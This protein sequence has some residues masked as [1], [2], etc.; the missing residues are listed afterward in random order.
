MRPARAVAR[1]GRGLALLAAVAVLVPPPS[2]QPTSISLTTVETAKAVDFADGVLWVLVLGS[3]A[4]PGRDVTTGLTDAIQLVGIDTEARRAV[5]LGIPRDTWVDLEG[6]AARLN[7][8]LSQEGP[9]AVAR[10]VEDLVGITP[11]LVLVTGFEGFLAMIGSLGEIEVDSTQAFRTEDAGMAVSRGPNRFDARQALEFSRS[12]RTLPRGDFDRS[13]NHQQV[14]IGALTQLRAREDDEGFVERVALAAIE[15]LETD[16]S[17]TEVYRFVQAVTQIDPARVSA[18][19]IGGRPGIEYGASVVYLDEQ[20][21]RALAADARDDV[22]LQ[23][24]CRDG[25]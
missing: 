12:R 1:L 18:C 6:G 16:L 5:A 19:V 23:G 11:D 2:V 17:P 15:G 22:R 21:A 24:G 9:A 20:Q 3:D 4:R 14:L 10:E 13:A 7:A 25:G 8:A